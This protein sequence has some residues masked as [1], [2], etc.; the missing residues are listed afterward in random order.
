MSYP[1]LTM[2]SSIS[3]S[4]K[5]RTSGNDV[6]ITPRKLAKLH[7]DMIPKKYHEGVDDSGLD[8]WWLD[9]CKNDGSYYYQFPDYSMR[10]YCEILEDKDF[11]DWEPSNPGPQIIIGNPPYSILDAWL[12]H[13]LECNPDCFSYLI[14]QG[15]LTTRRMEWIEDAGYTITRLHLTKVYKWYGMSYIVVCEKG[16]DL[17]QKITKDRTVWREDPKPEPEPEAITL[18]VKNVEKKSLNITLKINMLQIIYITLKKIIDFKFFTLYYVI[19]TCL[20]IMSSVIIDTNLLDFVQLICLKLD[21]KVS[22]LQNGD[23][24]RLK[25]KNGRVIYYENRDV[26]KYTAPFFTTDRQCGN[27]TAK[28]LDF[29]NKFGRQNSTRYKSDTLVNQKQVLDSLARFAIHS[30][31][32]LEGQ[33]LNLTLNKTYWL[34]LW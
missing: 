1:Q 18:E 4:I 14:G 9:P 20:Y 15:A 3:H 33:T 6:F 5:A 11:F 17:P 22:S 29:K 2:S 26:R 12:K 13:T 7:I 31:V 28:L 24:F 19:P 30:A 10:E 8:P 27:D 25:G 21:I 34:T 16:K 23:Y 32:K